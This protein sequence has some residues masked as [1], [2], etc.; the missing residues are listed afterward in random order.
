MDELAHDLR[1]ALRQLTRR[2][3]FTL[4][5]VVTL[6]IGI[7][8]NV[9]IFSVMKGLILRS[10]AYPEPDRV[11]AVWETPTDHR[12]YQPFASPDYFDMREQ[13]SSLKELGI[14]R[15]DWVNLAGEE[16][17]ARVFGVRCTASVLRALGV[18]PSM[19][20]LFSDDEEIDGNHRVVILS[21]ALWRRQHGATPD[22]IG[23]RITVNG[24]SSAVIG[25]MP[26][27][28]EFPKPWSSMSDEPEVWT[29]LVLVRAD[30]LRGWHSFA[31]LGRLQDGVT[32]AQAEADLRTIAAG[33]AEAYP[34]TNA[35]VQ[36]WID[37]LMRRAL[38]GVR[39][40]LVMLLGIVGLVL[41]IACANVASMLLARG[42]TRTSELAIRASM[43]AARPRLIRQL[44][45]E[46]MVLS[47]MG[48]VA[49]VLIA[50][51]TM[52]AIK[53]LIPLSIPR[54]D[55]I[56]IDG[57]VLLFSLFVTLI[58][59]MA[60]GLAPA[61]FA[62]RT[63][64]VGALKEGRGSQA[65]GHTR[66]RLLGM[67]VTGQLAI[68]CV[69]ANGA[70]LLIVSYLEVLEIP[71]GFATEHVLVAGIPLNGPRYE[72]IEGRVAFWNRLLERIQG[73]PGVEHGAATN[74]LPLVGGNNGWVLVDGE[75]YDPQARRPLVEFS[76]VS[77]EYFDA[78]GIALLSGRKLEARDV[79]RADVAT[80]RIALVN[81]AF[82][83][84]YWP[85][86][87]ALGKRVRH[88]SDP[89]AWIATV[90]GVVADVRQWGLEYPPLPEMYFP[91]GTQL[92]AYTRLVVRASGD[93][94]A[95]VPALRQ[96][97]REI[98]SQIPFSGVRTMDDVVTSANE[99]R[100]FY[101]LLVTLFAVTA[102]ILVVAGTYGV[103]S[104]YVSQRTHEVGVRVALGADSGKVLRLFLRQ[105]LRLILLGL[106]MGLVGSVLSA[107]LTSSLAFGISPLNPLFMAGGALIMTLL[108]LAAIT[109]PVFRAVRVDPN[110]ALRA[111]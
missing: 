20:R 2:P 9:A 32:V 96:A 19:G 107:T 18:Q 22:I 89:P 93:P 6:A 95:L 24:E 55:G 15:F 4:L 41:L 3:G 57:W 26:P 17:A 61:L 39:N 43:G 100:R 108:A 73:L 94:Q 70:A 68:A 111:E 40:F 71:Q 101:T 85:G 1:F 77:P 92:W 42:T 21:D 81:Q 103:M 98:D 10:L 67:L 62:S 36:V 37:P 14:Y 66:N 28:Y 44:L 97:V 83:D 34:N 58:T 54:V 110:Q 13:N 63:D 30:S 102:L 69:L 48:G 31:A 106:A 50:L 5:I 82:V 86:E 47:A 7:G 99:R 59:G 90:V 11:V 23:K 49:G 64:L 74:K 8:A 75:T 53:D 65:G 109:V 79:A 80:D 29:P 72:E 84:R 38:G 52:G 78:M 51:G 35:Q 60:F 76:Y 88:N 33:L 27:E 46:S 105:G 87:S 56:A 104:Y 12:A 16:G 25:V 45:T 91:L